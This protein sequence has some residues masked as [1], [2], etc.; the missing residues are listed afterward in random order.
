MILSTCEINPKIA[1]LC[2]RVTQIFDAKILGL[3][4]LVPDIAKS[5]SRK[6]S[7][8]VIEINSLPFIDMHHYP[9]QGKPRNVAAAIWQMVLDKY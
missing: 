9:Y 4:I 6:N 8:Y 3:D 5:P 2:L 1:E 7:V